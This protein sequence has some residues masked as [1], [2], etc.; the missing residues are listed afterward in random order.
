MPPEVAA[1]YLKWQVLDNNTGAVVIPDLP[2]LHESTL[3]VRALQKGMPGSSTLGSFRIPLFAPKTEEHKRARYLYDKLAV[4]QR[5][6][7]YL[8]D[9]ITGSPVFSGVI[10]DLKRPLGASWEIGGMDS[11]WMLQQSQVLPGQ[12]ITMPL[13][14]AQVLRSFLGTQECVWD[15]DFANW[16]SGG[17]ANYTNSGGWTFSSADPYF[18]L[19]ALTASS[20]TQS[21]LTTNTSWGVTAQYDAASVSIHGT[22]VAGTDTANAGDATILLLSDST[23]QN[24]VMA[25]MFMVQTGVGSGLWNVNAQI[26]TVSGG[27]ATSQAL[28]NNV[29]TNVLSVFPF[30]VTA[31]ISQ[32]PVASGNSQTGVR[33]LING[34]DPNC[35]T[36]ASLP[37]SGRIGLRYITAAGGSPAVYVNRIQFR[38]RTSERDGVNFGT[39]RFANGTQVNGAAQIQQHLSP[40]GATHLDM[41]QLAATFDGFQIRKN[42]KPGYKADTVDYSA[43]PGSDLSASVVFEEGGN[44]MAEGTAVATVP[45]MLGSDVRLNALPGPD[46]GGSITWGRIAAIG[47]AILTDTVTD[48]GIGGFG[49]LVNHARQVQARKDNP[50]QAYRVQVARTADFVGLNGGLGPRELDFVTVNIPTLGVFRARQQI[51]GYDFTEAAG[52]M[53][54]YLNQLPAEAAPQHMLQRLVRPLDY[55]STTYQAR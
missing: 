7:A 26:W 31:V 17:S 53:V 43:S 38:G 54:F 21:V 2:H 55:L 16:N 6:E 22:L 25:Q 10:T 42:P 18:G 9:V 1:G 3:S 29:F 36:T 23:L 46:S 47:D 13:F 40:Q 32:V 45:E 51:M 20:T 33:I 37:V 14:A 41:L 35:A 44:V 48:V 28:V 19:P 34:K 39:N 15:D 24:G 49:L 50:L 27:V 12:R 8:G 52:D 11:L 5:V 30:E 4:K